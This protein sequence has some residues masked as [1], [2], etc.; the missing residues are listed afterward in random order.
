[1]DCPESVDCSLRLMLTAQQAPALDMRWW[2]LVTGRA[3]DDGLWFEQPSHAQ[4]DV[5]RYHRAKSDMVRR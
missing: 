2:T 3:Q 5:P 1:M 4:N